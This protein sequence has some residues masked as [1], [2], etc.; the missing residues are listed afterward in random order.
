MELTKS[1]LV[2]M[3]TQL[4]SYIEDIMKT[5]TRLPSGYLRPINEMIDG[6]ERYLVL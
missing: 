1:D 5:C 3:I 4:A 6:I 2:Q